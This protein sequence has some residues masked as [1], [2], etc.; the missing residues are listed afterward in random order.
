MGGVIRMIAREYALEEVALCWS[1]ARDLFGLQ[2][3]LTRLKRQL[4]Q[5]LFPLKK[6]C[7]HFKVKLAPNKRSY[8]YIHFFFRR[9]LN[10]HLHS[11]ENKACECE[12]PGCRR[13]VMRKDMTEHLQEAALS[14]YSL[15][16]GEIQRLCRLIHEKVKSQS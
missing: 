12:V 2:A 15:Q 1:L 7:S 4:T 5:H 3:G 6:H 13:I 11:C 14:H 8:K 16:S 9:N 10:L